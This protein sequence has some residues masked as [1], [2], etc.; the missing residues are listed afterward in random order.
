LKDIEQKDK[1]NYSKSILFSSIS[2]V[3]IFLIVYVLI[4]GSPIKKSVDSNE[5][6]KLNTTSFSSPF[7]D[8]NNNAEKVEPKSASDSDKVKDSFTNVD[9]SYCTSLGKSLYTSFLVKYNQSD[10]SIK[11]GSQIQTEV[12]DSIQDA[13]FKYSSKFEP[14]SKEYKSAYDS[15]YPNFT[16]G[17][18][19][20]MEYLYGSK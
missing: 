13:W 16:A 1:K 2:L 10:R 11:S 20:I 6:S 14:E 17:Q 8:L 4:P 3:A 18:S 7:L 5:K 15:Y 19:K 9:I 12:T